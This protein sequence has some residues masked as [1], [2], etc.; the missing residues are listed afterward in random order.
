MQILQL[1]DEK[2]RMYKKQILVL[3]IL[4]ESSLESSFDNRIAEVFQSI[5]AD[6]DT[7]YLKE[8]GGF[9]RYDK[10]THLL[11]SGSV[12][13]ATEEKEWYT[14][15]DAII[16]RFDDDEK[17]ILGICFGH[18]FLARHFA[19]KEH[20]RK[21]LTPEIGWTDIKLADNPIFRHMKS[22]KSGVFHFDEVFDLD[23]KFDVI[24]SSKRCAVHGFQIKGKPIWGIQ[25]H[26]DFMYED[27]FKFVEKYKA[28]DENFDKIHCQTLVS[29]EEFLVND[30]V[31]KNW[32]EIT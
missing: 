27:V 3:N 17:S 29:E 28:K 16:H 12:A 9:D 2:Y 30:F 19:G 21:S 23:D 11:L 7:I 22:F 25:F 1:K 31:F 15:L 8:L 20:V 18:Q 5:N 4:D 26:P 14:D 10:Y 24:A 13:S 32:I 6:Y